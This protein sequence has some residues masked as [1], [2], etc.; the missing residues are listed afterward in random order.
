MLLSLK[1]RFMHKI[2]KKLLIE[3]RA[4]GHSIRRNTVYSCVQRL[5]VKYAIDSIYVHF[6]LLSQILKKSISNPLSHYPH[7][8][9]LK[10]SLPSLV[11]PPITFKIQIN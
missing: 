4:P 7:N 10:S 8:I 9:C 2:A 1:V 11:K 6:W 3:K 5:A